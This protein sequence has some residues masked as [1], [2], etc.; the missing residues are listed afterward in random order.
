MP[1]VGSDVPVVA[2]MGTGVIVRGSAIIGGIGFRNAV[3]AMAGRFGLCRMLVI[4]GSRR[5]SLMGSR[6]CV[7]GVIV[8]RV[9]MT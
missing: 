2:C 3:G 1:A 9:L 5:G 4:G 6:I 8:A 7:I